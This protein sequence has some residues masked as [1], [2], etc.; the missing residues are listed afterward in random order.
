MRNGVCIVSDAYLNTSALARLLPKAH[1]QT[2]F[3]T[4]G[5]LLRWHVD[6]VRRR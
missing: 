6:L 2:L 5:T 1:R 4:P 3:V